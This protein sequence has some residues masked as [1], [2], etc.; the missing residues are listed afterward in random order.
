[1][2]TVPTTPPAVQ[3]SWATTDVPVG[4]PPAPLRGSLG[5]HRT[6][7]IHSHNSS[8]ATGL[9]RSVCRRHN[10]EVGTGLHWGV[11]GVLREGSRLEHN[12]LSQAVRTVRSHSCSHQR[13]ES[14]YHGLSGFQVPFRKFLLFCGVLLVIIPQ[15]MVPPP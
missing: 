4:P 13:R 2:K 1:V 8:P 11:R 3:T 9:S 10:R 15:T 12:C 7:A 5:P 6:I 14:Y